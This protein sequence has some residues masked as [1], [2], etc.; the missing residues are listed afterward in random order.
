MALRRGNE[1]E[2]FGW[3]GLFEIKVEIPFA[4]V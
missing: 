3:M 1:H 2:T 4:A